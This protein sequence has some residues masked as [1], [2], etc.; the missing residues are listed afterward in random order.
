MHV[1]TKLCVVGKTKAQKREAFGFGVDPAPVIF[2]FNR[3][4]LTPQLSFWDDIFYFDQLCQSTSRK[5][6]KLGLATVHE[7]ND[8]IRHVCGMD[9]GR[10]FLPVEDVNDGLRY[11]EFRI[12]D[13]D[14]RPIC[15]RNTCS[16]LRHRL[17]SKAVHRIQRQE[18]GSVKLHLRRR[19]SYDVSSIF[20]LFTWR[21]QK[22]SFV[23]SS[24]P[25]SHQRW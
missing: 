24:I 10:T 17:I 7:A 15:S 5:I 1:R 6:Q 23:L 12:P 11:I 13:G 4:L 9:N 25:P 16:L 19:Y 22:M 18:T 20:T 21:W 3:L 8:S 2:D 14:H